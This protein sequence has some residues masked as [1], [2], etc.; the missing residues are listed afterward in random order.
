[1]PS[2][3][4]L[5]ISREKQL[6]RP[7]G[8]LVRGEGVPGGTQARPLRAWVPSPHFTSFHRG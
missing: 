5:W 6:P 3:F 4:L 2:H 7:L 1:M 8:S